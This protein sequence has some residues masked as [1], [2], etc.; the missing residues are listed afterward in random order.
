MINR[1]TE[2]LT[3]QLI[4]ALC[5]LIFFPLM[6]QAQITLAVGDANAVPGEIDV[7]VEVELINLNDKVVG[8]QIDV[9]DV[10]NYLSCTACETTERTSGFNCAINE[11]E[12]GCCRVLL[13]STGRSF[14]EE[15]TGPVFT[16]NYN[17]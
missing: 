3:I 10:D 4:A 11:I 7:P 9:C 17:M 5:F 15:G 12:A 14:V 2:M 8:V 13:F 16:I 1:K 6:S